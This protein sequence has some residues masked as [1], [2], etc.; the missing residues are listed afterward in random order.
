MKQCATLAVGCT[1]SGSP[2]STG[3]RQPMRGFVP[4]PDRLVDHMVHVL[5]E[6]RRVNEE[7]C[8]LD[9]GSGTGAFID[10][11]LRWSAT[12]GLR[13]PHVTGI[14]INSQ[15]A[16]RARRRFQANRHINLIDGDFLTSSDPEQYDY[17][18]SNPPYV[19]I[20]GLNE[21]EKSLYRHRYLS[22][23]GRFDLYMLFFE[24][25]LE[26]LKPGG[27]LVFVTPEKFTYVASASSLRALLSSY[28]VRTLELLPEDTFEDLLTYPLI[29]VIDKRKGSRSTRIVSR[30]GTEKVVCLP[31]QAMSWG[32][33]I[34]GSRQDCQPAGATTPLSSICDRI[35][36]GIATGADKVFVFRRQDLPVNLDRFAL[37]TIGGRTLDTSKASIETNAVM[38]LP[39]GTDGKLA[40]L[41]ELGPF[42]DYLM[43][44]EIS[45]RLLQRTCVARKPWYAFHETPNLS[46]VLRPKILCKDIAR[47][48]AFWVDR[49]GRAVPRH[50]TYY[51][52][53]Q[54][55]SILTS[56]CQYLNSKYVT[57]WLLE[58]CQ[59]AANGFIRT[60][61]NVLK[62]LPVPTDFVT[63]AQH[64]SRLALDSCR[65]S[66]VPTVL[67]MIV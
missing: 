19:S 9:P 2:S 45:A 52:V 60:Q 14:E 17:V 37:P 43:E 41:N 21:R 27:R 42:G 58:H 23:T 28:D 26:S 39:Y 33:L 24:Q 8:L 49:S 54:D 40:S 10:G 30:E 25:A 53:P 15:L 35:S 55:E 7:E 50:S 38:L 56:L 63:H 66:L 16:D 44:P 11:V 13:P 64:S 12:T 36:C 20:L 3:D 65:S 46:Q 1:G 51:I 22:A 67:E 4:T 6:G 59:R 47:Q 34:H 57:D 32:P 48:P 29:T 31:Q 62:H 5:F 61:S 18:I